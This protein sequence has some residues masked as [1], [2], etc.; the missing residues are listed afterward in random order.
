MRVKH[1]IVTYKN[2]PLLANCIDSIFATPTNHDRHVVVISN[3]SLDGV[4]PRERLTFLRNHARPDFSTGHLAR[5]W[6][7]ALIQ[8]FVDLAKPDADLVIA[9]QND[10]EFMPGYLEPLIALHE[11]YDM[12]TMGPG[13]SCVS[14][15]PAAI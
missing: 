6:N 8:G 9:C 7:Q 15:T 3:H 5:D 1:Y 2:N 4:W 11:K 13:D 12:I 14:Y 10:S